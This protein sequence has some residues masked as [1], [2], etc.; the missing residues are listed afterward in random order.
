MYCICVLH[1]HRIETIKETTEE[2]VIDILSKFH[3]LEHFFLLLKGEDDKT[4][5]IIFIY[6]YTNQA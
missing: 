2:I 5:L 4:I 3:I 6:T 1:H